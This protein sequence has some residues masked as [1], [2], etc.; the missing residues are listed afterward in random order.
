MDDALP[1]VILTRPEPASRRFAKDLETLLGPRARILISPILEIVHVAHELEIGQY[2][3]LILTSENAL[4]AIIDIA[5]SPRL[6]AYAV[7]DRTA[8]AARE[9]GLQAI[10][11]GGDA[12]ALKAR[13]LRD[14]PPGPWLHASGEHQRTDLAGELTRDGH[15]TERVVVYRQEAR[16][17]SDAALDALRRGPTILP[18]FSP[19]SAG[20]LAAALP[21]AARPPT[22]VAISEAAAEMWTAPAASI[23]IT[24]LPNARSMAET[25]FAAFDADSPC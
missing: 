9:A 4:H 24:P 23:R 7:G 1:T 17:L 22:V 19:R 6:T 11:A 2:Q 12:E 18:V 20:L 5:S 8:F 14:A 13:L 10:S 15:P 21:D 3:T 25:T 16:A